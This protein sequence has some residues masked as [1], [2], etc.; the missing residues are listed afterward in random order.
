MSR[1]ALDLHA[2]S[3]KRFDFSRPLVSRN[4]H[5]GGVPTYIVKAWRSFTDLH[6]SKQCRVGSP[7]QGLIRTLRKSSTHTVFFRGLLDYSYTMGPKTIV[8]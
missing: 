2:F 8:N 4:A 5:E 7:P 3:N 1:Q 6:I